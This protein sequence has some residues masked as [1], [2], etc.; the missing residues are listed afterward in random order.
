MKLCKPFIFLKFF[1]FNNQF[2][3]PILVSFPTLQSPDY[4]CQLCLSALPVP[5]A[6]VWAARR[7]GA[8][9]LPHRVLL[10]PRTPCGGLLLA[11]PNEA[12]AWSAA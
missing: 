2:M 11:R 8:V 6:A 5:P 12:A 1:F 3:M 10:Q 4:A 9:H 7:L